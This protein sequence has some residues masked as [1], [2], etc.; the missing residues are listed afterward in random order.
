MEFD[1]EVW[2]VATHQ[3]RKKFSRLMIR[4]GLGLVELQDQLKH[5]DIEMTKNYGDLNL[6][7]E[8]QQEKFTLSREK[9]DEIMLTQA[10]IIGG[11]ADEV[12]GIGRLL[13]VCL[14]MIE[15]GSW[16]IY[17]RKRLLSKWMMA[18]V[19]LEPKRRFVGR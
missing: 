12:E 1:G 18:C 5:F 13:W 11:G 3:F 2:P 14:P 8:L 10:P 17:P 6:Y 19:C 16:I 4:S 7:S 9:Y 15:S